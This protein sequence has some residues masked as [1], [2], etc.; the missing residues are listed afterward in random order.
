[1]PRLQ[2][3]DAKPDEHHAVKVMLQKKAIKGFFAA[4]IGVELNMCFETRKIRFL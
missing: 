3:I 2:R 1:M 4:V